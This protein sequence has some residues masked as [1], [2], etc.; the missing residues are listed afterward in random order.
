MR[1]DYHTYF[2]PGHV[3][4]DDPPTILRPT[5]S[6]EKFREIGF[7]E[8]EAQDLIDSAY[9][10]ELDRVVIDRLYGGPKI[11]ADLKTRFPLEH[12]RDQLGMTPARLPIVHRADSVEELFAIIETLRGEWRWPL[13]FRGQTAHYAIKRKV[14]NPSFVHPELG[15]TSL[16]PSLWRRVTKERL[17]IWHQFRD[18]SRVEWSKIMFD[19]F[20]L[21]EIYRLEREAGLLQPIEYAD[22]VPDDPSL[23]LVRTF[24]MQ[25]EAFL[26]DYKLDGSPIF[27]TLLQHY[28]LYSP[29]LDLTSDPEVALFFATQKFERVGAHCRYNF[30]GSNNREAII[31]VIRHDKNEALEY[32]RTRML[33]AFDP[34]RPTRQSCVIMGSNQFAMNLAADFLVAA[35]R[36]DFDMTAPGRL[37]TSD[38]FPLDSADPMLATFKRH[39]IGAARY[40]LT[41]FA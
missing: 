22:E 40:D 37:T 9:C 11:N 35:I 39:L 12:F 32:Q 18:L 41:D 30:V 33:E 1:I 15:E 26:N 36:L 31:Y 8:V 19:K 38:L 23:D 20:N 28:G 4:T 2:D 25:R 13:L 24:H 17:G 5:D 10:V 6:A 21:Q 7:S 16:M 29:V 3:F 27:S 14:P 34:Q